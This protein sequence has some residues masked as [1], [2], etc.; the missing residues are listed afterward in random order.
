MECMLTKEITL[1]SGC[2]MLDVVNRFKH[3]F[4]LPPLSLRRRA[5]YGGM[6]ICDSP[7]DYLS[8]LTHT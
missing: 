7:G 1:E 5:H 6:C 2:S 4:N 3:L 8:D